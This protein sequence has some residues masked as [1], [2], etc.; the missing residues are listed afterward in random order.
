MEKSEGAL[1]ILQIKDRL[2]TETLLEK[3]RTSKTIDDVALETRVKSII[4]E[5]KAKGDMALIDFTKKFDG[6][7]LATKG[8]KVSEKEVSDACSRVSKDEIDALKSLKKKIE[9][10]ERPKLKRMTYSIKESGFRIIN[11]LRP[12]ESVGCY[13]PGGEAAYPSTLLM[14]AVPAKVAGVPRIVVCSP[15]TCGGEINPLILAAASICDVD[16]V[17]RFGGAQAIAAL[18]YGTRTV[19]PVAKIVGP[20][21][22]FVTLAKVM[23][24]RNTAID[25]P[26]GPSEI[27]VLADE[28]ANPKFVALDMISQSEHAPDNIAGLVTT[29]NE[30]AKAVVGEVEKLVPKMGRR[31]VVVESLSN[32]GFI[33]LFEN[34]DEAVSFVN[35]FAP[36]HLEII[37]RKC[38]KVADKVASAGLILLG[39]YTPVAASDYCFGTNHVLPTSGF[40]R[41]YSELSV[42]DYVRRLSLVKCSKERLRKMRNMVRVLSESEGLPNHFS[43]IGGRYADA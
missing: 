26:A 18:A 21:N 12:I 39:K 11:T 33:V 20:G 41:V 37:T 16:E 4:E 42:F 27:V 28:T 15:P 14:T 3:R 10:I 35:A 31:D 1:T 8:V 19:K 17:Y 9:K 22:K 7:D 2:F 40:G 34:M 29:S 43:A 36:E 24:S 25:L 32:N 5:V 6:V 13:V 23:V 38:R 30:F